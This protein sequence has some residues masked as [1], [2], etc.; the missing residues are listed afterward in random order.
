[1][2]KKLKTNKQG[3]GGGRKRKYSDIKALEDKIS[4]YFQDIQIKQSV[5]TISGL[6]LYL[7][8]SSVQSLYEYEQTPKFGESIKKARSAIENVLETRLVE[9][10]PPIGLIFALKNRFKWQD[11]QDVD[12]TSNGETLGIIELPQRKA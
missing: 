3:L 2:D 5:P 4:A 10:K 1:M 9:G 12:I 7:G 6:S 8:F 11:K